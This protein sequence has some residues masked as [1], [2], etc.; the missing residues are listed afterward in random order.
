MKFEATTIPKNYEMAMR[1]Q[2]GL[3]ATEEDA[4]NFVQVIIAS[5]SEFL[6]IVKAKGTKTA[7]RFE[8]LKG[9]LIT[10]AVVEHN[11]SSDEE[12]QDNW[13]YYWTF[14]ESDLE[15]AAIHTVAEDGFKDIIINRALSMHR[16]TIN[17]KQSPGRLATLLIETIVQYL[18]QNAKPDT[19][20]EVECDGFFKAEAEVDGEEI[21]K[22]IIPDGP[23]KVLI[24]DDAK[25][26]Q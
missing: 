16:M 12:G 3:A 21:I 7:L 13:N 24:K 19:K 14:D 18:E 20:V 22:A 15:G 25:I 2:L 8:D 17:A 26:E 11:E 10:A 9:N 5:V 1:G 23:M 4:N 6:S